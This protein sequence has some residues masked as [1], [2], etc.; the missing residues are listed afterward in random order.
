MASGPVVGGLITQTFG[1]QS[2]FYVNPLI[3]IGLIGLIA[4]VLDSSK[5]PD[6]MRLDLPGVAC[7]SSALFL[8]TLA[9]I[10]GNHR[11]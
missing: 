10:E 4:L 2:A 3:G 5:D 1:W 9:L 6:A 7:F 11:G 8:V